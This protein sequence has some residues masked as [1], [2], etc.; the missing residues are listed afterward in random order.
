MPRAARIVVPNTAHH[1]TQRGNDRQPVFV[2][3]DERM[4]YIS[5]LRESIALHGVRIRAYCLM[6]NHIHLLAVPETEDALSKAIGRA[7]YLYANH[8]QRLHHRSGHFWQG[9]FYSCALDE[10]HAYNVAAYVE[11]NPVRAGMAKSAW[12]YRWSSAAVHCLGTDD[13]SGLLDLDGWFEATP[14]AEWRETLTVVLNADTEVGKIRAHTLAGRPLGDD[15]F[16]KRL[17]VSFGR[18]LPSLR[19]RPRKNGAVPAA[20][21]E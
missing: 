8:I 9:R 14:L 20:K 18:P 15:A 13:T 2:D 10:M 17:E 6:T 19:G 12:E 4:R 1:V 5:Y 7:H 16:L 21:K 11:L 3:D